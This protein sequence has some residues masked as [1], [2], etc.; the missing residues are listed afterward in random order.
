MS[1]FFLRLE[2]QNP[3]LCRFVQTYADEGHLLT[4]VVEHVYKSIE[5]YLKD[6]LSLDPDTGKHEGLSH[7]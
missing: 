7:Q 4:N 5:D 1:Q 2:L 6:C 3:F